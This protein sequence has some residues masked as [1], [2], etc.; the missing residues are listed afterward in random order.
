MTS[1]VRFLL[2]GAAVAATVAACRQPV[3]KAE[4]PPPPAPAVAAPQVSAE[5]PAPLAFDSKTPYASVKLNLPQSLK[6]Q[7][8]LHA[9][10]YAR[11][12]RD[13][14]QFL[15]GAQSD[16]TE[17]G[18]DGLPPYEKLITVEAG[19][20]TGKL[21]SLRREAYEFTAGAHGNTLYTGLLWDKAMKREIAPADLFRKGADL[22]A[23][24]QALC[25]AVNQAKTA[26]VPGSQ[27]VSLGGKD[28]S[29]P[30][31]SQTP[32]VL[33]PGTTPGKAGGLTFMIGP[34]QVGPYS[35]GA[36]SIAVPQSVFRALLAPAYAD[37]FAG[38]PIKS[39]DVTPKRG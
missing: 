4:A 18:S 21:Y 7:P 15:E 10:V 37:E 6:T 32:F 39:G 19:A 8:D 33:T 29:C 17:G 28:W 34:Y 36:Y 22:S 11:S 25:A 26:R 2:I 30:R 13:L 3:E 16:H 35:D 31:A 23:L 38:Q 14:R 12:V 9:A 20:E 1:P 24:D 27:P 5:A